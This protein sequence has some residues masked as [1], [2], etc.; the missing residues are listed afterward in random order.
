MNNSFYF[1][2]VKT[3]IS[4]SILLRAIFS[5]SF[6]FETF[7][8]QKLFLAG[9]QQFLFRNF[10][11]SKKIFLAGKLLIHFS[12]HF[13]TQK[14]LRNRFWRENHWQKFG[15]KKKEI[16]DVIWDLIILVGKWRVECKKIIIIIK[17]HISHHYTLHNTYTFRYY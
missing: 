17:K 6:F 13:I 16:R 2:R 8:Y 1:F 4:I 10:S 5:V 7:L 3:Q 11:I 9:K 15:G 14:K 12:L